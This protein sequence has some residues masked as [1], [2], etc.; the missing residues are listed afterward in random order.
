MGGTFVAYSH[1]IFGFFFILAVTG[2]II[3]GLGWKFW[4]TRKDITLL[5]IAVVQALVG[6]LIYIDRFNIH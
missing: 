3:W 5:T 2:A 1:H 4:K 6:L